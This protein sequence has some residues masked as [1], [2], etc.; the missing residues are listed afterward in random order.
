MTTGDSAFFQC[1]VSQTGV[2]YAQWWL[3]SNHLQHNDLNQIHC[4]G[5]EHSLM[6]KMVTPDDSGIVTFVVGSERSVASLVV[7][8]KDNGTWPFLAFFIRNLLS[9]FFSVGLKPLLKHTAYNRQF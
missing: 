2:N 7:Q 6:L 1:E 9:M 8:E 4:Q 5:K 3:G